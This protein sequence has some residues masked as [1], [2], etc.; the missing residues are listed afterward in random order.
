MR[1]GDPLYEI[2]MPIM[3]RKEDQAWSTVLGNL[4]RH[5]GATFVDVR[6][7]TTVIDRRRL[8]R[9]WVN[10]WHNAGIRSVLWT[11]ATPVRVVRT[12][13]R[14]Q[15]RAERR[16]LQRGRGGILQEIREKP[17]TVKRAPTTNPSTI[18]MTRLLAI[19]HP[20]SRCNSRIAQS[21]AMTYIRIA[22]R[23]PA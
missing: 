19:N 15:R 21:L 3:M 18:P 9:N 22:P 11:V 17:L 14:S 12:R 4:S 20:Y 10:V 23:T 5:L 2:A 8:W 7:E 13:V 16:S 6:P 1:A